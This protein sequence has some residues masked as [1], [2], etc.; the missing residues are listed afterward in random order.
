MHE[1]LVGQVTLQKTIRLVSFGSILTPGGQCWWRGVGAS[2][3][4]VLQQYQRTP[5]PKAKER[6]GTKENITCPFPTVGP[7]C[8]LSRE[9][10]K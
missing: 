6:R 2:S 7:S 4:R 9:E 8:E 10:M 5:T 3:I 1:F